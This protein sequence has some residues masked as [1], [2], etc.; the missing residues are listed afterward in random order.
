MFRKQTKR[1]DNELCEMDSNQFVI[2]KVCNWNGK[3]LQRHLRNNGKCQQEYDMEEV[4]KYFKEM[5]ATQKNERN[6]K[7]KEETQYNAK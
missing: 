1:C 6:K 3:Q 4:T 2:C 7:Y 5:A